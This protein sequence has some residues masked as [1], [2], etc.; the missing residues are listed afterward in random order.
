MSSS[1]KA[2]LLCAGL[3]TRLRPITDTIPKCLVEVCGEPLLKKWLDKLKALGCKEVVINTHYLANKV[4][5]FLDSYERDSM[6]IIRS[7]E[8]ELLGT[9][10]TLLHHQ[11]CFKKD[12][13]LVI[14]ADNAT[15]SDLRQFIQA[16][17]D[18]PNNCVMTMLTFRCENPESCGIA[19]VDDKSILIGFHE[20]KK[21]QPGNLAN[22]AV[23]AIA[24]AFWSALDTRGLPMHDFSTEVIPSLMGR[25]YTW[26]LNEPF[27]DIGTPDNLSKAQDLLN[28]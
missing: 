23:Y 10:G 8:Q 17:K 18:R 1:L 19:E 25:I 21:N 2:L 22:G 27:L 6:K 15:D 7:H 14:H 9:A 5:S 20:K 3:G 4:N 16:H 26:E 11:E 12:N 13:C 24:P 28:H